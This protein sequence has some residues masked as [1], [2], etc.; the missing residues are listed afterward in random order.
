M[1]AF[2]LNHN[3]IVF[4]SCFFIIEL[5]GLHKIHETFIVEQSLHTILIL[6]LILFFN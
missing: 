5:D 3:I 4:A 1:L 2:I 6:L